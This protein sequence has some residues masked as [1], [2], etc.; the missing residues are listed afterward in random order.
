MKISA[1]ILVNPLSSGAENLKVWM[2]AMR[3]VIDI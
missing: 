3:L 2:D 1:K